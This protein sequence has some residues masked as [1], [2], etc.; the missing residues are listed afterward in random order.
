[1]ESRCEEYAREDHAGCLGIGINRHRS[2]LAGL[3]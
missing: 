1:M 2:I 3:K